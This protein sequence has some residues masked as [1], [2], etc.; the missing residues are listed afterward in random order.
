M[1]KILPIILVVELII[2]SL[3]PEM[4]LARYSQEGREGPGGGSGVGPFSYILFGIA[5]I[6][7]IGSLMSGNIENDPLAGVL[8]VMFFCIFMAW[9]IF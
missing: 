6:Y 3:A 8:L 2:F 7:A 5:F 9:L 1:N 4:A